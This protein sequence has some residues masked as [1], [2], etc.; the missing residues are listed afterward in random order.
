MSKN[1][2]RLSNFL[3]SVPVPVQAQP[4][5]VTLPPKQ[6]VVRDKPLPER[7][8]TVQ[9]IKDFQVNKYRVT[10][11]AK[12]GDYVKLVPMKE[13]KVHVFLSEYKSVIIHHSQ[14]QGFY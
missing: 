5:Q 12:E 14:I 6:E 2:P 7:I 13:G 3:K 10:F 9:L 11:E 4:P 8:Q 1:L